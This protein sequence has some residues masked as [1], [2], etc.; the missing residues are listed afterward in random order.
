MRATIAPVTLTRFEPT[1]A[2]GVNAVHPF[3]ILQA[4]INRA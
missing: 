1:L 4:L 2:A 3:T